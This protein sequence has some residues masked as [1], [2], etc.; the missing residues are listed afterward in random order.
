[1]RIGEIA[2]RA[3]VNPKT[4]RYYEQIELLPK[5]ARTTSGYRVYAES[6]VETILFI[7][8]AQWLGLSLDEI[9]QIIHLHRDGHC[10]CDHVQSLLQKH[11]EVLDRKIAEL[12]SLKSEVQ[13]VLVESSDLRETE[14]TAEWCPIINWS[15]A[16][17]RH[18]QSLLH[19]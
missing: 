1:M 4:I 14:E 13:A 18:A 6:D 9:R 19:G 12:E 11:V 7:K 15:H 10:P 16:P 2:D 17:Q 8:R 5:P 3:G